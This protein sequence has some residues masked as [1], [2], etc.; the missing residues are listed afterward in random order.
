M[1]EII[2]KYKKGTQI[3][4]GTNKAIIISNLI[5]FKE[6][7]VIYADLTENNDFNQ[8][9]G[10][11]TLD[12]K[13][14][15]IIR[16][17]EKL[18]NGIGLSSNERTAIYCHE[19]GHCFSKNQNH[20]GN[21]KR[22]IS[23]EVDAD[24]FAVKTCGISPYVLEEALKKTYNYEIKK[25]KNNKNISVERIN[26]FIEEMTARKRNVERLIKEFNDISL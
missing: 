16:D 8:S 15:L 19:L 20:D 7:F 14:A 5:K 10:V 13:I 24:T 17:K 4:I 3:S 23:D 22:N 26:R 6:Y 11:A 18:V 12:D 1:E 25:A 21:P 2:K 9:C